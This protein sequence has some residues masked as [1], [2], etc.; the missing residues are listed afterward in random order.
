MTQPQ[1][2]PPRH[3]QPGSGQYGRAQPDYGPPV[4]GP[5]SYSSPGNAMASYPPP[6]PPAYRPGPTIRP[7]GRALGAVVSIFLPGVGSMIN[8]SAGRGSIILI[9]YIFACL[10]CLVLIGFVLAPAVWVWGIIDGAL[11]ADRWNRRHG[12][13]S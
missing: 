1:P 7:R 2:Y 10:L 12:I 3:S 9:A 5:P 8:G 11:S 6:G 4:Q 13:V